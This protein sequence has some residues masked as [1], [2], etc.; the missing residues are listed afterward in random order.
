M[1]MYQ[2]N[3]RGFTLIE[4]LVVVAIVALL[5]SVVFASLNTARKKAKD[6]TIKE[7]ASQI[8]NL[9]ALNYDDYQSFCNLETFSWINYGITCDTAFSGKFTDQARQICKTIYNNSGFDPAQRIF[10]GTD[11]SN[12]NTWS[13]MIQLNNGNWYCI[14]SSGIKAEYSTW[15]QPT[16][17]SGSGNPGCYNNP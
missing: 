13:W 7:A 8:A 3:N 17:P 12:C 4:L 5:S 14:S 1:K 9:M 2:K 16:Y 11:P 6:A 10:S 15:W